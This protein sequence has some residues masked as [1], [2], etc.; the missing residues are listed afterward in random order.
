MLQLK[1][2]EYY[3][4]II[5]KHDIL[6]YPKTLDM[7][8]NIKFE[9]PTIKLAKFK[10]FRKTFKNTATKFRFVFFIDSE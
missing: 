9:T 8:K 10:I 1:F 7:V 2:H 5:S 6:R 3:P 4:L